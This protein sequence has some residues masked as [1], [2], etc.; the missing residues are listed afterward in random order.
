MLDEQIVL[1]FFYFFLL[2]AARQISI[3]LVAGKLYASCQRTHTL[4]VMNGELADWKS[5]HASLDENN[6]TRH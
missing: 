5:V 4:I 3:V 6:E 1:S 2:A